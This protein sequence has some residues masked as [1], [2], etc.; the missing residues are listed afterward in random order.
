MISNLGCLHYILFI[1][2][3]CLAQSLVLRLFNTTSDQVALVREDLEHS[4]RILRSYQI[5]LSLVQIKILTISGEL[6]ELHKE[7]NICRRKDL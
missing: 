4:R 6:R 5:E 1:R 2:K 3:S 7:D